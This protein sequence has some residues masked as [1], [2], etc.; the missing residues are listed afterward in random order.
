MDLKN[1]NFNRR[2][3][4]YNFLTVGCHAAMVRSLIPSRDPRV[5]AI[6]AIVPSISFTADWRS[7]VRSSYIIRWLSLARRTLS[8]CPRTRYGWHYRPPARVD[9]ADTGG[10]GK[11][12]GNWLDLCR[13][14]RG[15]FA[16]LRLLRANWQQSITRKLHVR[17]NERHNS[18]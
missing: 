17:T 9:Y 16:T 12:S 4:K 18:L 5:N 14:E 11:R 3:C 13:S 2:G 15:V 6:P 7:W 8:K 10:D 1:F